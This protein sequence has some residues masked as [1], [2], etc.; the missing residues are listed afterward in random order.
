MESVTLTMLFTNLLK[1]LVARPRPYY[2]TVCESYVD[3]A[4]TLCSGAA[5]VVAEARKSFP[6]GHSSLSFAS[7]TFFA[8]TLF[9]RLSLRS[10][11]PIPWKTFKL[12]LTFVPWLVAGCIS[13]SR[14][15]DYHHHYADVVGGACLGTGVANVVWAA[16]GG[17]L[18][19]AMRGRDRGG[20]DSEEDDTETMV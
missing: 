3:S 1:L 20:G 5:S 10:D 6:S 9:E 12:L 4:S 17:S 7:A 11:R 16:R 8:L 19:K 18:R 14:L 2:A 15:I 13:A